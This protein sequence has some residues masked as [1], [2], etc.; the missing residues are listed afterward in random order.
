MGKPPEM[1]AKEIADAA[2]KSA[3]DSSHVH[4]ETLR[5]WAELQREILPDPK[6][7]AP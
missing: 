4:M 1:Q 5:L 3:Q 6:P 2:I 7:P